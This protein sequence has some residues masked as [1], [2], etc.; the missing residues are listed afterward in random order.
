MNL[1][2]SRELSIEETLKE[3]FKLYSENFASLFM[4]ML[5]AS[6][7]TGSFSIL[8]VKYAESMPEVGPSISP[9]IAMNKLWSYMIGLLGVSLVVGII[10]LVVGC[11]AEGICVKFA[12]DIIEEKNPSLE[13]SFN[14]TVYKL[15]SLLAADIVV[16]ILTFLGF[17]ALIVPGIIIT[18]MFSLVIQTIMI[19]DAGV[20]ESLSRS[21]KLVSN[22]WLKTFAL[23]L[24]IYL[25]VGIV[26][27]IGSLIGTPFGAYKYTVSSIIS[28]FISPIVPISLTFHY[29]SMKMKEEQRRPPPPPPPPNI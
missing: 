1:K 5:I 9:E 2:I 24:I 26:S 15:F 6:L 27:F 22:R 13:E 20:L 3:A 12:A 7:V 8:I 16:A 17:I 25:I 10:S 19:E 21:R 11:I 29:Y 14:F 23:L 4:P 18:I 28:A